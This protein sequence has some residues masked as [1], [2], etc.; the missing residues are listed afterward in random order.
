MRTEREMLDRI[1]EI[2]G[3]DERIRAVTMEGSRA[4][5]N[6]VRD[7]YSDFDITFFA[8]D[9]REFTRDKE[10]IHRLGDILIVQ[11]PMDWYS[12][13]YDYGSREPFAFLIQFADGNRI[14][15]TL[16]DV[17]R[18]AEEEENREPRIVLL[19]KD[20][21]P[22]LLPLGTEEAFFIQPPGEME[23]YNTCNEFRWVCLYVSKGVCRKELY[24]AKHAYDVLAIPMFLKMLN[25]KVGIIHDFQVSTGSSCKYLKRFL[26][27]EEMTRFRDIFPG[28][29]YEDICRRLFLMYDY[30]NELA[31]FVA[32][33]FGFVHDAAETYRVRRFLEERLV[34]SGFLNQC[35]P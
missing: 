16:R 15:L 34:L 29:D 1:L 31:G 8:A 19:N 24:Y 21:F 3:A 28:G 30:F 23:F 26:S 5:P 7:E 25:W 33:H 6:A 4:N 22:S 35:H 27:E 9:V 32:E 12:H 17:S 10:W 2:S 14:D 18:I 11:C 13:P 20:N